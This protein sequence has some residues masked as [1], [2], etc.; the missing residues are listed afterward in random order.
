MT[1]ACALIVAVM[2]SAV[3]A[4]SAPEQGAAPH[5]TPATPLAAAVAAA[6]ALEPTIETWMLDRHASRPG[7]LHLLYGTLGALQAL[8][9]YSTRRAMSA[10]ANEV[11]PVVNKASGN[12]AAMLAVKALSTVGSIYFAERAWKKNRKGAVVLMAVVNGVTAAVVARN[13]RNAR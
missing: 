12:Q 5:A 11:N 10:G 6:P 13:L 3:P 9:V 8:D 2:L 1:A 4:H 7:T